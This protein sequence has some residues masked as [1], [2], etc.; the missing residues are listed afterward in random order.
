MGWGEWVSKQMLT[1]LA[2]LARGASY[3]WLLLSPHFTFPRPVPGDLAPACSSHTHLLQIPPNWSPMTARRRESRTPSLPAT[4]VLRLGAHCFLVGDEDGS[5]QRAPGLGRGAG[6]QG[7][8]PAM[9]MD[10]ASV[11]TE[12]RWLGSL[13]RPG[14]GHAGSSSLAS[15]AAGIWVLLRLPGM[16]TH[17]SRA[18]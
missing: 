14:P 9:G 10:T 5:E 7:R 2:C 12:F 18:H 4:L 6:F 3:T 13:G 8:G 16:G 17:A 15:L 11:M 1:A